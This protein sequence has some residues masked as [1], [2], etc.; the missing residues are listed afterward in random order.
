LKD[1]GKKILIDFKFDS[2]IVSEENLVKGSK[3]LLETDSS[4]V[5]PFNVIIRFLILPLMFY[6]LGLYLN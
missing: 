2:V 1:D 3:R 4:L 6:M 5:L